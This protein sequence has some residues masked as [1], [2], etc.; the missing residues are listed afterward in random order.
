LA[1]SLGID[2]SGLKEE[3]I[4]GVSLEYFQQEYEALVSDYRTYDD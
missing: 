4:A 3:S 2:V 1:E